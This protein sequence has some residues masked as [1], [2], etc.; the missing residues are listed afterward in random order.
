MRTGCKRVEF[1]VAFGAKRSPQVSFFTAGKVVW[2][3]GTP[4][5]DAGGTPAIRRGSAFFVPSATEGCIG[6]SRDP[7]L[8]ECTS[9]PV[10]TVL[11]NFTASG[12]SNFNVGAAICSA[13][14]QSA[15]V[16]IVAI[17]IDF[18]ARG[19]GVQYI[20][21]LRDFTG[22]EGAGVAIVASEIGFATSRRFHIEDEIAATLREAEIQG[23]GD[24]IHASDRV[25]NAFSRLIVEEIDGAFVVVAA[26]DGA[27][28]I[29]FAVRDCRG[30]R[31]IL[32]I[33]VGA[34][35]GHNDGAVTGIVFRPICQ[36]VREC[37]RWTRA[38]LNGGIHGVTSASN[39]VGVRKFNFERG[40]RASTGK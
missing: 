30:I 33:R 39:G 9:I 28:R 12:R 1:G 40:K 25:I 19:V 2:S 6:T 5:V 8:V 4:S 13:S 7:A 11:V 16:L 24:T 26:I 3:L 22:F 27:L 35:I 21:T 14:I 31:N 18:A 29:L 34:C 36:C 38:V 37:I 20:D 15:S 32:N 10:V 23:A 17:H